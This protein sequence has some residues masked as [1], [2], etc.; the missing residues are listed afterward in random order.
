[1]SSSSP[2]D[3]NDA[4]GIG[5]KANGKKFFDF[6]VNIVNEVLLIIILFQIVQV[7]LCVFR[8]FGSVVSVENFLFIFLI[9]G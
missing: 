6:V 8:L 2:S 1:M 9:L 7:L 4:E 3:A 5:V